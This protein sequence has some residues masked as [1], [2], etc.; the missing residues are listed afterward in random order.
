MVSPQ[1][2]GRM[3]TAASVEERL[4]PALAAAQRLELM[5]LVGQGVE[6]VL[7]LA[8][9]PLP[10]QEVGSDSGQLMICVSSNGASSSA[11][12]LN[13]GLTPRLASA[14]QAQS[15]I[16]PACF[17][18]IVCGAVLLFARGLRQALPQH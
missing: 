5:V 6:P 16:Y 12:L 9:W 13:L 3:A 15:G 11:K 10:A 8:R 2:D 4:A 17:G 18:D 14:G 1:R 7:A